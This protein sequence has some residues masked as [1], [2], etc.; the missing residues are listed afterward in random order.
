VSDENLDVVPQESVVDL[1]S[2]NQD[3]V[4]DWEEP[5]SLD[6]PAPEEE[7]ESDP[8]QDE[9]EAD[10][11]GEQ[12]EE[13]EEAETECDDDSE[14]TELIEFDFGGNKLEVKKADIPPEL[15]EKID[16]FSKDIWADYTKKSQINAETSKQLKARV[17]SLEKIETLGGEA[18]NAFTRGKQVRSEIEQ[19]SQV[20]MQE[21]WRVNPDK[22]RQLSDALSAKQAELQSIIQNVDQ[23]ERQIDAARQEELARATEEGRQILDRKYKGFSSKIAPKLEAYAVQNGIAEADAKAWAANPTVAEFAYKAMLYDQMQAAGRPK[24]TPKPAT[25]V[26]SMK[27]KGANTN[28]A[29]PSKMGFSELGK[30]LGIK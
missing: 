18:L 24:V 13:N 4:D 6:G 7:A 29:D 17:E 3:N 26:R 1:P 9:V 15:A 27:N 10:A 30:V 16:S 19:L 20:N 28:S 5:V 25:P 2:G 8:K 14:D 23:Y 11:D 12:S 22:A 21:M